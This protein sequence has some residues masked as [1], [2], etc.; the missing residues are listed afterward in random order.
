MGRGVGG[1]H[2]IFP[3]ADCPQ[4]VLWLFSR[5]PPCTVL[6]NHPT[7]P[8]IHR[9]FVMPIAIS[10]AKQAHGGAAGEAQALAPA[11]RDATVLQSKPSAA[12][13]E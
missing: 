7:I 9:L 11:D 3:T 6:E 10:F 13:S 8:G 4:Q 5:P 2:P 12:V 1:T